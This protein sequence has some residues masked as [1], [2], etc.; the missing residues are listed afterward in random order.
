MP[1]VCPWWM[2]YFHLGPIRKMLHDP[3]KILG[4][5]VETGMK[6]LDV[7]P[8]MGFFTLYLAR[9]VG[10]GGRVYA[11]DLQEKM[12]FNLLILNSFQKNF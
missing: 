9:M 6:V 3:R 12:I 7:G 8:G 10:E 4:S 1:H 5:Y 2:G 11:I